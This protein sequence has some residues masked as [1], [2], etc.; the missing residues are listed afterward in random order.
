ML[1]GRLRRARLR[2][3]LLTVGM[4]AASATA[5]LTGGGTAQ[6]ATSM[7]CDIYAAGGTPCIAAHSTTRALFGS[8]SGPLYQVQRG[9]DRGFLDVGVVSAG[10]VANAA[11]QD[12]FCANSS[13]TITKLYDQT[14]NHNDL[15]IS[16]GGFWKGPGPN[17][18]DVGADAKALPVT[19]GG[20]KAYGIKVTQGVGY[21]VDNARGAP[22]GSQPEGIYLVTSSN[23]VNQW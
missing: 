3:A 1:I 7:P 14:A 12:S 9:S 22:T 13:C 10:G 23:F 8:Y 5:V 19:V 15:P 2:A 21:R 4:V 16:W 18:A 11:A 6:A 17:G 20:Q